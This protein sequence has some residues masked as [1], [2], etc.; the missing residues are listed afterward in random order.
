MVK[1][2]HAIL[3]VLFGAAIPIAAPAQRTPTVEPGGPVGALSGKF[4]A[5][6]GGRGIEARMAGERAL[7]GSSEIDPRFPYR[8]F[9][10][11]CSCGDAQGCH[12]L[13]VVLL[14]GIGVEPNPRRAAEAFNLACEL[15]AVSCLQIGQMHEKGIGVEKDPGRALTL[16]DRA[17]VAGNHLACN[18]LGVLLLTGDGSPRNPDRARSLFESSCD[19]GDAGGCRLLGVVHE[20]GLGVPKDLERT[21]ALYHRACDKGDPSACS[22][23]KRVE[24]P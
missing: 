22:S 24:G 21:K 18:A 16:Y 15:V 1:A 10:S 11:A 17:C 13:G 6:P 12:N 2:S 19:A 14:K 23:L 3:L 20:Q 8:M 4:E 5:C 9:F 7:A